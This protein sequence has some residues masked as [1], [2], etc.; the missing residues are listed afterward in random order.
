MKVSPNAAQ[1]AKYLMFATPNRAAKALLSPEH[2]ENNVIY[3]DPETLEKSEI[4][5][6]V[7]P[8]IQK[9]Q[10]TIFNEVSH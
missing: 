2:L 7:S 1:L 6:V 8:E 10:F 5:K 4:K 9:L 3:T